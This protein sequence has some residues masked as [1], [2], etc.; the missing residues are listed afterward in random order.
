MKEET[1][2]LAQLE[3]ELSYD[4]QT[5]VFVR[6]RT[7]MPA[8]S[9][10]SWGHRQIRVNKRLTMAHRIAWCFMTGGWPPGR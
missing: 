6:K 8:G 3:Q 10:D 4:P 1:I 5:G 9:I 7:G 2:S